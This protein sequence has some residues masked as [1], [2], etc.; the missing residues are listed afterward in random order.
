MSF[1]ISAL[2]VSATLAAL[3]A[4]AAQAQ[5]FDAVRLFAAPPGKSGGT[6]GAAAIFG[7][8]YMGSDERRN[9]LVPVL[10]YQWA[11]GAFAGVSNG[12]GF[13]FG[14]AS[15]L[16]YGLRLTAD[17]GRKASRSTAL[18]GM[19]DIDAAVEVGGFFNMALDG[20]LAISS[21]LRL[22]SGNDSNGMLVDLGASYGMA[23][24]PRL[25]LSL[26]LATT[27]ANAKYM[28]AYYGVTSSQSMRSGN[29]VY[30]PGGG[31]R[32]V[33]ASL[34]MTYAMA[35]GPAITAGLSAS[36]LGS[37]AKDSPL[38][39][40]RGTVSGVLAATWAF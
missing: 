21:S 1:R 13:N 19:D 31:V 7:T 29:R 25:R 40:K 16:Q 24:S 8:D 36:A 33:R 9:L 5:A 3:A 14:G 38:V 11:N 26:G 2:I 4:P 23:L 18:R 6:Y 20:G 15:P 27:L 12:I 37:D 28:Q 30:T 34:G 17:L 35:D 39:R 10:D 22:G 32:D